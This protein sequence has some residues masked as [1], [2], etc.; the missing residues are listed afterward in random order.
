[1]EL[2]WPPIH[3]EIEKQLHLNNKALL[4]IAPFIKLE[5]LKKFLSS[6]TNADKLKVIVKWS[7]KDIVSGTSDLG[8]YPF[9]KSKNIPLYINQKIHLKLFI[10]DANNA[11]HTSANITSRGLGYAKNAN[12]EIGCM[13]EILH[14]DWK[15]I[16]DLVKESR[17]VN[18][19]VYKKY[20]D[21]YEKNKN[22]KQRLPKLILP[23]EKT[24]IYSIN[25][26]PASETPLDA[27]NYYK[28][29]SS[30][31]NKEFVRKALHDLILYNIPEGL[32]KTDFFQCLESGFKK[33][34][35]V[36]TVI[37]FI[38]K[39]KSCRFGSVNNW[40]HKN[41]SDV[42]LPYRWEIKSNTRILYNWLDFFYKEI[43]WNVPGKRSQVIY[44]NK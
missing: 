6:V 30:S 42:P 13:V 11:F 1:M 5:A 4:L 15:K 20:L 27:W 22:K 25:S 17:L 40:I 43:T 38:K 19:G 29:H 21:Y 14:S 10:F 12:V 39:E 36:N 8:I 26:L 44:W 41:C 9:L 34:R 16:Y 37:L 32:N 7:P 28:N 23:E 24:R 31:S 18:D 2:N 33:S 3:K 35:F